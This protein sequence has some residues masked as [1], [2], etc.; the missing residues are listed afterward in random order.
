MLRKP[1]PLKTYQIASYGSTD[2]T[3]QILAA[4][5]DYR[6][7][8]INVSPS[9][10]TTF[11]SGISKA[12]AVATGEFVAVQDSDDF[13]YQSRI[14]KQVYFLENNPEVGLV[15]TGIEWINEN[16]DHLCFCQSLGEGGGFDLV[17]QYA[18]MNPLAHSSV[19]YR[20]SLAI[21]LGGYNVNYSQACDYRM[22][23]DI[24]NSG[25]QISVI[26]E[27][28]VKIRQHSRQETALPHTALIRSEDFLSLLELA[29][30]LTFLTRGPRI[31]GQH[32]ITK[33]KFQVFLNLL[34]SGKKIAALKILTKAALEAPFYLAACVIIRIIR[35]QLGD[36]PRPQPQSRIEG[37]GWWTKTQ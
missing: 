4:T 32:Q 15:G 34:T 3:K 33:T 16:G 14:E 22:A 25:Y 17:Q 23:L 29:Q 2:A 7:N 19:M 37:T 8:T 1:Q 5:Q 27:P 10:N 6:L 11:A 26:D 36:A 20:R 30:G 12:L 18:W 24:L 31:K 9:Q 35:G 13:S 28:L 21:K